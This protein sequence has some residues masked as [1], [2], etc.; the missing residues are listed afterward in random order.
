MRGR[1]IHRHSPGASGAS[2]RPN[3]AIVCAF[4]LDSRVC[5]LL[6]CLPEAIAFVTVLRP[7]LRLRPRLPETRRDKSSTGFV[8][9]Q[10]HE[11]HHPEGQPSK[12]ETAPG[13]LSW[14]LR[15]KVVSNPW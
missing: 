13:P 12:Q 2:G 6:V 14:T 4:R 8:N 7:A 15:R 10:L 1:K 5:K 9:V 11:P 3:S